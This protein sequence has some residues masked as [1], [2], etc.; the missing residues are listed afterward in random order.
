MPLTEFTGITREEALSYIGQLDYPQWPT[1]LSI[2]TSDFVNN[3]TTVYINNTGTTDS[4]RPK[5]KIQHPDNLEF[6]I[7]DGAISWKF[8]RGYDYLISDGNR[9]LKERLHPG[10]SWVFNIGVKG[11]GNGT[12]KLVV[13]EEVLGGW[14]YQG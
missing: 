9:Q 8:N 12:C 5:V 4:Y 1:E 11:N 7:Y 14:G 10:E 2:E 6:W 3:E 13:S